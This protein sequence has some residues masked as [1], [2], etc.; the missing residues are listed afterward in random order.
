M[1]FRHPGIPCFEFVGDGGGFGGGWEE[2]A[3]DG[4]EDVDEEGCVDGC[5]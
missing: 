5:A 1:G 2:D 4:V 3:L